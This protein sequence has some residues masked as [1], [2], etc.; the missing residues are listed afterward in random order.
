MPWRDNGPLNVALFKKSCSSFIELNFVM[1]GK[2]ASAK[3]SSMLLDNPLFYVLRA[4]RW[5]SFIS[6]KSLSTT[7]EVGQTLHAIGPRSL[8]I[9]DVGQRLRNSSRECGFKLGSRAQTHDWVSKHVFSKTQVLW[10]FHNCKKRQC[11]PIAFTLVVAIGLWATNS[12]HFLTQI[13]F[14]LAPVINIANQDC[15]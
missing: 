6:A 13:N 4:M 12:P 3:S 2:S 9:R 1:E 8:R 10:E 7:M 15:F 5:R 11:G 14:Q